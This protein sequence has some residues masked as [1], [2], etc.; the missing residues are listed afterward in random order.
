MK[1]AFGDGVHAFARWAIRFLRH[2]RPALVGTVVIG[3]VL[4]VAIFA[5]LLTAHGGAEPVR[6]LTSFLPLGTDAQGY[7]LWARI[8]YGAR[9][10]VWIALSATLLSLVLGVLVGGIS[11]F[12]GGWVDML[13]MRVVDFTMTFPSFL[14]AM[15]MVALL[16]PGL[17]QLILAVGFVSS[18]LIARQVRA[19]VIRISAMEYTHA[20]R[21]LGLSRTRIFLRHVL[22]NSIGPIIVLGTLG[23]G[24]AI[25]DVAGLTFLGLGGDPYATPEWGQILKQGWD[26]ASKGVVQVASAG[27][28]IFLTVLGFNLLGDGL[29]DELDPRTRRR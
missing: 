11:G 16:G 13:V 25:L 23:M 18:P 2:H 29:K 3:L 9:T 28:A 22:P 21:A 19:E 12:L 27:L 26:E 5:G 14:L 1:F 6:D 17:E 24:S 20:A 7:D 10:T 15:V 4:L 8:A